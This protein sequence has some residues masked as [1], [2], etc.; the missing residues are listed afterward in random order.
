M[1][2]D[3]TDLTR[4]DWLNHAYEEALDFANYL[5]RLIVDR[6]EVLRSF[7]NEIAPEHSR[8]SCSDE[9]SGGNEFFNEYGVPRCVRC[10][11]LHRVREGQFPYG[12]G[13]KVRTL[14]FSGHPRI[15]EDY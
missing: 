13:A 10:A 4:G 6:D 1:T 12:V 8:T 7:V 14:K 5:K 9:D 3:R 2:L 15:T 11:L